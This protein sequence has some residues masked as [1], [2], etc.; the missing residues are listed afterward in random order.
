M[1]FLIQF[2]IRLAQINWLKWIVEVVTWYHLTVYFR[3]I[4]PI[5]YFFCMG[6]VIATSQFS[7]ESWLKIWRTLYFQL[8]FRLC[9]QL[10]TSVVT[11][12]NFSRRRRRRRR[13]P[14]VCPRLLMTT[15]L[16]FQHKQKNSAI[17]I[18]KTSS[19]NSKVLKL[20]DYIL[21]W[22]QWHGDE[23]SVSRY[24]V[25]VLHIIYLSTKFCVIFQETTLLSLSTFVYIYLYLVLID[26]SNWWDTSM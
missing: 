26:P 12:Y 13:S 1:R 6:K 10:S 23:S 8:T 5:Q 7:P 15:R 17:N 2:L 20:N 16:W 14:V 21:D 9:F 11:R 25:H 3:L 24:T 19:P 18:S 22:L 4:K